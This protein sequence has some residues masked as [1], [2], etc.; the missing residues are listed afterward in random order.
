VNGDA[1]IGENMKKIGDFMLLPPA[2]D[3]CQECA[4]K[5]EPEEPHNA[6]SLYYQYSFKAE[7][8]RWPTWKDAIAHCSEEVKEAW[9]KELKARGVWKE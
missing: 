9:T 5:H 6:Q 3:V 1:G 4:T 2:P 7:H 8:G